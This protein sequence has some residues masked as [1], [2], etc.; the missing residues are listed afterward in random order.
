MSIYQDTLPHLIPDIDLD[1][2]S[3]KHCRLAHLINSAKVTRL[4]LLVQPI[5]THL[6]AASPRNV[7]IGCVARSG[8]FQAFGG[9][10]RTSISWEYF[11]SLSSLMGHRLMVRS[12]PQ[13]KKLLP[14]LAVVIPRTK[15]EWA[16]IESRVFL[17]A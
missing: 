11:S 16:G 6:N 10:R 2:T 3:S 9:S 5:T 7:L 15:P 8:Q 13:E 17:Q 1:P 12:S 4:Q 14:S